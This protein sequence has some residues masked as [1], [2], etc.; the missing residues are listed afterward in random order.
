MCVYSCKRNEQSM[1]KI[2]QGK[3]KLY[4]QAKERVLLAS[5]LSCSCF[6]PAL[7]NLC[8]KDSLLLKNVFF[9]ADTGCIPEVRNLHHISQNAIDEISD[10]IYNITLLKLVNGN[11]Q[12]RVIN[13]KESDNLYKIVKGYFKE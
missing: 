13:T 9:F 12:I 5:C 8:K 2:N 10:E 6:K 4:L 7:E 11:Y 3:A 1:V